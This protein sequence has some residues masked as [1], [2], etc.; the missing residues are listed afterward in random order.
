MFK[1]V[2]YILVLG[3]LSSLPVAYAEADLTH[4]TLEAAQ[5]LFH[6]NNKE[7]ISAK[8]MVQGA[9]A[10][11]ITAS[12]KPNPNLSLGVASF[13]LNRSTAN[14][15]P[16]GS[17]SL[18]DQTLNSTVQISQ[19]IER[20]DKR[21]LRMASAKNAI[22]ASNYDL[23]DAERQLLLSFND[24]YY[25]LLLAQEAEKILASNSAA[26]E[27]TIQAAELRLKVG[28]IAAS[29]VARMRVDLLKIQNDM[30]QAKANR[31]KAQANL[32]YMMGQ[33]NEA[34]RLYAQDGWPTVSQTISTPQ[35]IDARPDVLAAEART[36]QAEENQRL[37]NALKTRDVNIAL[38]YQRFPGQMPGAD[39]NTIG[40]AITIPLFTNYEYQGEISRA[41]VDLTSALEAKQQARASAVSEISRARAD[42]NAAVEKVNRFDT[43]IL[44]EAQKAA[45]AAEFAYS[46]GAT[47]ITDLLDA[48]RVLRAIQLDAAT[49]HADYAKALAA[50]QAATRIEN[51]N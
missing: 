47:G 4:L 44:T 37:A 15:N 17:N 26:Y 50:W 1:K 46:H 39:T 51:Q 35:D 29:D 5:H 38:Q 33:E 6:E 18:S 8:R 32:A 21:E 10:D 25:D 13:N 19:L 49:S 28:D 27:K 11:A 3:F 7:L 36:K 16:N 23:K 48:R 34:A 43:Q 41:E 9:E 20:G 2:A 14:K 12:Q 31:E 42:L 40:A 24:A 22:K 30:R 45:D